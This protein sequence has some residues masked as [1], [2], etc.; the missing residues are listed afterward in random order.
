MNYV[1][2]N[3]SIS[4]SFTPGFKCEDLEITDCVTDWVLSV[5]SLLQKFYVKQFTYDDLIINISKI[6][7]MGKI[8]K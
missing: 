2:K 4:K 3:I 8:K 7:F 1:V 6:N 5:N